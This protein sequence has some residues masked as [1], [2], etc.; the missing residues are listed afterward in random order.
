MYTQYYSYYYPRILSINC[1]MVGQTIKQRCGRLPAFHNSILSKPL[2]VPKLRVP[3]FLLPPFDALVSVS[4][5]PVWPA[6]PAFAG[7]HL[8]HHLMVVERQVVPFSL[9]PPVF[10]CFAPTLSNMAIWIYRLG[11]VVATSLCC[12]VVPKGRGVLPRQPN[13]S[14]RSIQKR[15][16]SRGIK[17]HTEQ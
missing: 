10:Y 7:L 13:R 4:L 6:P 2:V 11:E 5:L 16:R 8:R 12:H 17:R 15:M 9:L 14:H 3:L 1:P